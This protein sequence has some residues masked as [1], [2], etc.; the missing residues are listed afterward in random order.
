MNYQNDVDY[1][2]CVE[3]I[4]ETDIFRSMEQYIQ[5]GTTNCREHSLQVSY[6]TY[7]ICRKRG[8]RYR[9]AARGALLHDFFL[10]DWHTRYEETGDFFHGLRH[11]RVAMEN[12]VRYF[13]VGEVEQD[14]ILTHMWPLTIIPP[15]SPEGMVL[16]YADKICTLK[17][18]FR[19]PLGRYKQQSAV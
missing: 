8:L 14:M 3:D 2:D 10:Y 6:L 16:V 7:C 4:L 9:L 13:Q 5:H 1:L 17:E 18:T 19:W 15:K 11:P 12:A